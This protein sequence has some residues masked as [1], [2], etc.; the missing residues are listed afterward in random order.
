MD[1]TENGV[2]SSMVGGENPAQDRVE[3]DLYR[4]LK[5]E[6]DLMKALS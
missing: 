6:V 2:L 3:A 4:D 5:V 1:T